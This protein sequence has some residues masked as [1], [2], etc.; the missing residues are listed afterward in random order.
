ME[1]C[2]RVWMEGEMT[3]E[4]PACSSDP[5]PLCQPHKGQSVLCTKPSP[6]WSIAACPRAYTASSGSSAAVR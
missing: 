2:E 3:L 1:L 4:I 6:C 5:V